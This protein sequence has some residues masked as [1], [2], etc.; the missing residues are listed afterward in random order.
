MKI[1]HR[2]E[3]EFS[4]AQMLYHHSSGKVPFPPYV[5]DAWPLW[6]EPEGLS[7]PDSPVT[8]TSGGTYTGLRIKAEDGQ[9]CVTVQTNQEVILRDCDFYGSN[10]ELVY[11]RYGGCRLVIENCRFF[12]RPPLTSGVRMNRAV[13][14]QF[15]PKFHFRNN[16]VQRTQGVYLGT[17]TT[18]IDVDIRFNQFRAMDGRASDGAGGFLNSSDT[19][20]RCQAVQM[21]GATSM[22][23]VAPGSIVA[24]NEAWNPFDEA[25]GEDMFSF[26]NTSGTEENPFVIEHN[27]VSRAARVPSTT[28]S[29]YSGGGIIVDGGSNNAGEYLHIRSNTILE[30]ANYGI[31]IAGGAH[32]TIEDNLIL[33]TGFNDEGEALANWDNGIYVRDYSSTD[34][35]RWG[36]HSVI[37][38][39]V[40]WQMANGSFRNLSVGDAGFN[41]TNTGN[42][43]R[44][45]EVTKED[46]NAAVLAYRTARQ[47]AGFT[48]GASR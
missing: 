41:L 42:T 22:R 15:G 33:R 37:N 17:Y 46:I 12:G 13:D 2:G 6:I 44:S 40:G 29:Q 31:A 47:A 23:T 5:F 48:V 26:Y 34:V 28:T 20:F 1:Q 19:W 18:G 11:A 27:L 14:F 21:N 45:A 39:D 4:P 25:W 35:A 8:I 32:N 9:N 38:N 3:T 24:W 10:K 36:N 16:T 7:W 43:L 30:S